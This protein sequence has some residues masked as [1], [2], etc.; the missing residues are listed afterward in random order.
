MIEVF[1]KIR[2]TVIFC[3]RAFLFAVLSVG[4]GLAPPENKKFNMRER[5]VAPMRLMI[6]NR[7]H[8]FAL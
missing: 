4:E 1:I 6:K 8:H 7:T 3:G 5:K 2:S